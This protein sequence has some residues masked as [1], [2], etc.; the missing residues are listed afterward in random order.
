MYHQGR[1]LDAVIRELVAKLEACRDRFDEAASRVQEMASGANDGDRK[2]L[3]RYIDGL[4][5]NATGTIEF[6]YDPRLLVL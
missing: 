2:E 4:R 6:W 1:P 3:L 5:T